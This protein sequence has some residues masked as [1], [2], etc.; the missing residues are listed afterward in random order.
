MMRWSRSIVL[1]AGLVAALG[2]EEDEGPQQETFQATLTGGAER[3]NPVTTAATGTATFAVNATSVDFTIN[4]EDITAATAAHIHGPAGAD[5]PAG[6]LV[7]L[8]A[9]ATPLNVAD[10]VL[11]SGT[12]P[13]TTFTIRT[14]VSL[15]SVLV[16]MRNGNAYVNVH[17]TA[18]GGGEIRGQIT[19]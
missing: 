17:T 1:V 15:D 2:C 16:L 3:P 11:S 14:G 12:F 9:P 8:F 6:V 10:G 19:N 7:T 5:A 13:S 18:N 4:V